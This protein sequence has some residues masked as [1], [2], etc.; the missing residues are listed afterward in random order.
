MRD[1][2]QFAP[3]IFTRM[4]D[5]RRFTRIRPVPGRLVGVCFCAPTR[6]HEKSMPIRRKRFHPKKKPRSLRKQGI[7]AWFFPKRVGGK[8]FWPYVFVGKVGYLF[9]LSFIIIIPICTKDKDKH[10]FF[11]YFVSKP[12]L[13]VYSTRPLS[14]PISL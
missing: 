13:L 1:I 10:Y 5:T 6:V 14:G 2:C 4:R 12:M 3:F 9:Y 8:H 11:L 7:G